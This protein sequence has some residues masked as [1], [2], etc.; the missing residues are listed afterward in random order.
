LAGRR[1]EGKIMSGKIIGSDELQFRDLKFQK[2][3]RG[4]A[5]GLGRRTA[6]TGLIAGPI[7]L[8]LN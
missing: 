6:K 1:A 3:N 2:L 7:A 4:Y 8:K 5:F